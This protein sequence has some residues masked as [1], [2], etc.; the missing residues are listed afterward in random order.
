[1]LRCRRG[2]GATWLRWARAWE[3]AALKVT[4]VVRGCR[5]DSWV[6]IVLVTVVLVC[7]ASRS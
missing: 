7:V 4:T 1:M 2:V 6:L 5:V 3:G